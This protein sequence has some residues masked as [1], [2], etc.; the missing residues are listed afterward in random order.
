M[1]ARRWELEAK[2]AADKAARTK[3]EKDAAHHETVMARLEAEAV[4]SAQGQVE[5]ELTR[6]QNILIALEYGRLKAESELDSVRQVLAAI[7]EAC[8]KAEEENGRLADERLSLLMELGAIK[9]DFA[10][11]LEK[12]L[13]EKSA[14]KAEFNASSDVIFNY[15]YGCCAFAHNICGSEPMIPAGMPDTSAPLTLEFFVNP[16]Y[17]PG[18]SSVLSTAKPVEATGEELSV[19][20]LPAIEGGVDISSGSPISPDKATEG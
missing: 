1:T 9:E 14:L 16:R 11:F 20:G 15:G 8:R 18:S 7:K 12:S 17:P 5:L 6:V 13:A 2:E 3:V 10:T 4:V 19:K